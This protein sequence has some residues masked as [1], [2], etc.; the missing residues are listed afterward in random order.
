MNLFKQL[1][2]RYL[3]FG[4]FFLFILILLSIII[5]I[6]YQYSVKGIV[7]TS[8]DYQETQLNLI[9]EDLTSKIKTFEEYSIVLSRQQ[10]FRDVISTNQQNRGRNTTLLTQDFSNIVYSIPAIHSIEIFLAAPP[11]DNIQYPVRYKELAA[12]YESHWFEKIQDISSTWLGKRTVETIAGKQPVIS[13]GRKINTSRGQLQSVIIINLDPYSVQG[14]LLGFSEKS[15]FVLLDGI[16]N[17]IASTSVLEIDH[18]L[19]EK[20]VEASKKI[21]EETLTYQVRHDDHFVVATSVSQLNWT[22]MQITPYEEM[23]SVSK[24]MTQALVIIGVIAIVLAF[25]GTLL[26]T[27]SFTN[28][29]LSLVKV[30]NHYQ[31][32]QPSPEL[33][34]EYKN[35]FGQLF[36]GFKDLMDRSK[37]L[38]KSLD[39]QNR[40]QR[41]AEIKAL[42]A[43]INPHFL[44]NTL[45]QL[46]W[47]AIERGDNDM[48]KMLELLGKMLRIGLSKGESIITIENEL[49]Y[50]E[51]Y[52]RIQK[53][54]LEERLDYFLEVPKEVQHYCIPKLTLQPFVE[55]AIIHGF[56][57]G[58]KG[59]VT[60]QIHEQV[61]HLIIQ[62]LDDGIGF[63][64]IPSSKHKV[65][66]GGYG[67]RNV[68]E[69]LDV[70][71]GNKASVNVAKR[72]EEGTV[73]LIRI[74]KIDQA[75]IQNHSA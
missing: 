4:S 31:M 33:P 45:D 61:D 10:I 55:N 47:T 57:D 9:S 16:G 36:K 2:I 32:N 49:K 66:T 71:Y 14:W 3:L 6:S 43:N 39:E 64:P 21:D 54:H 74:P 25:I 69:R 44:Y 38:Y 5:F 59:T 19:H 26:L 12:V 34:K 58:R 53:I 60:I 41:E 24:R 63:Q 35:E 42:Q 8:T 27:R 23:I 40:R 50:L 30:M 11:V 52:L 72:E 17:V 65:H 46:N 73:V 29:L 37:M 68:V 7:D 22:I 20:L 28:P 56:R 62:V 1:R 48:S 67:I 51:Y 18:F 15:N 13:Y 70:Y 75:N